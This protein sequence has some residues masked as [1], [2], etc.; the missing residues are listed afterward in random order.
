MNRKLIGSALAL[1]IAVMPF[2]ASSDSGVVL[3]SPFVSNTQ[4]G[5]ADGQLMNWNA[6]TSFWEPTPKTG[7]VWWDRTINRL[8]V[9]GGL[10][11]WGIEMMNNNGIVFYDATL[12]DFSLM[13]QDPL[14]TNETFSI[15]LPA[16]RR[17]LIY[18]SL[19]AG[20]DFALPIA[21]HPVWDVFSANGVAGQ[22]LSGTHLGT[23]GEI[24]SYTGDLALAAAQN[25]RA[26]ADLDIK[27]GAPSINIYDTLTTDDTPGV[28]MDFPATD[29]GSGTE[30]YD[31]IIQQK[32]AGAFVDVIRCDADGAPAGGQLCKWGNSGTLNI[33]E[34]LGIVDSSN[35]FYGLLLP[36]PDNAFVIGISNTDGDSNN[37]IAVATN[38]NAFKEMGLNTPAQDTTFCIFSNDDLDVPANRL[39]RYC[40]KHD[41]DDAVLY[42]PA[43]SMRLEAADV[44]IV[45][46]NPAIK[47]IDTDAVDGDVGTSISTPATSTGSGAETYDV[48]FKAQTAGADRSWMTLDGDG[49]LLGTGL[50]QLFEQIV[51]WIGTPVALSN[52]VANTVATFAN[53]GFSRIAITSAATNASCLDLGKMDDQD[54]GALCHNNQNS[55]F[56]FRTLGASTGPFITAGNM[57][58]GNGLGVRTS[59]T[60]GNTVLFQAYD[61]GGTSYTTLAT[62]TAGT[63][64]TWAFNNGLDI[65]GGRLDVFTD[66][67]GA[68]NLQFWYDDDGA[69]I[70]AI[71]KIA[72]DAAYMWFR[73]SSLNTTTVI[74]GEGTSYFNGGSVAIGATSAHASA[75][76]D[77]VSTSQGVLFPRMTNAQIQAIATPADGLRVHSTDWDMMMVYDSGRGKWLSEEV[78]ALQF[79]GG[80]SIDNEYVPFNDANVS[81]SGPRMPF[82]GAIT[83]ITTQTAGGQAD[84]GFEVHINGVSQLGYSLTA[85]AYTSTSINVNFS[86]GDYLHNYAV[87]T[88]LAVTDP[89]TMI[90]VKWRL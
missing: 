85:G 42:T 84:K 28:S 33:A 40:F 26:E 72:N 83:R 17:L 79:G 77:V 49:G 10:R 6:L 75:A 38:S 19:D 58:F 14:Q 86:A 55:E 48:D 67:A 35:D 39:K 1:L 61:T 76:L 69:T 62:M 88:G 7:G 70:A 54:Y 90:W 18:E 82:D 71:S 23:H 37:Y 80:T 16:S 66:V 20:I 27:A 53:N 25:V 68:A 57:R 3:P 24:K 73:D 9:E 78:T 43:G 45:A 29:L 56:L 52:Q 8:N 74:H 32:I 36:N 47:T 21:P 60:L 59:T 51:A 64:P 22:R 81:G 65:Y 2:I 34:I 13:W 4:N 87:A 44:E 46:A 5:T 11:S 89:A 41:G 31:Y 12:T 30:D 50:V 15:A 63:T